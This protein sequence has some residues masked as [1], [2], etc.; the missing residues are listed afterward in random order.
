MFSSV[1]KKETGETFQ[2]LALEHT[3]R[4]HPTTG[5]VHPL[6]TI[7]CLKQS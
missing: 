4:C 1:L 3:R 7:K 5:W 2:K 6:T